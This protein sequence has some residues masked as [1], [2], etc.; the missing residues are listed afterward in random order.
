MANPTQISKMLS[1]IRR[2][3]RLT[4]RLLSDG[5]SYTD[6]IDCPFCSGEDGYLCANDNEKTGEVRHGRRCPT[7]QAE[8]LAA[9]KI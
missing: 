5:E 8:K 9:V 4:D 3:R 1:L 2:Y 6:G 7:R